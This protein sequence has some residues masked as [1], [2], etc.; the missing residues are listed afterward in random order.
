M[1]SKI[2]VEKK[3]KNSIKWKRKKKS[4]KKERT[5]NPKSASQ[6]ISLSLPM[7]LMFNS[8]PI[9]CTKHKLRRWKFTTWPL[10]QTYL[11]SN[12][13]GSWWLAISILFALG[14]FYILKHQCSHATD[15][16]PSSDAGFTRLHSPNKWWQWVCTFMFLEVFCTPLYITVYAQC[17]LSDK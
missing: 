15:V 3:N 7:R 2:D 14:I 13:F 10:Y 6:K 1:W 16:M 12:L 5:Q 9:T 17:H 4:R 11:W 8:F